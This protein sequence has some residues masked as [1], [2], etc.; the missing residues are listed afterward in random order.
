MFSTKKLIV[1]SA[2]LTGEKHHQSECEEVRVGREKVDVHAAA[3]GE[4][5]L[6]GLVEDGVHV[7]AVT[8]GYA[9]RTYGH[10]R[11]GRDYSFICSTI[12]LRVGHS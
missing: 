1:K 8:T 2:V 11:D 4:R 9:R 7:G 10:R 6:H 3:L 5:V 12:E